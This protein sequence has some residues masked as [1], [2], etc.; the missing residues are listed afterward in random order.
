MAIED[1]GPGIHPNKLEGIFDR[2]YSDRP[3]GQAGG[4]GKHSGLGLSIS[5]QIVQAVGGRI[6]AENRHDA[7]GR[8]L[9]ARFIVELPGLKRAS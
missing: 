4:F 8:V 5:R 6:W 2:F 9:G 3:E 1:D 7:T